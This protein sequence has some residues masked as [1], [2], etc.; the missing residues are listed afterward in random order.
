MGQKVKGIYSSSINDCWKGWYLRD[1]QA[2]YGNSSNEITFEF[3]EVVVSSPVENREDSLEAKL[4]LSWLGLIL[5]GAK[6]VIWKQGFFYSG[7]K[8]LE[9]VLFGR[10][11]HLVDIRRIIWMST[12]QIRCA[13][14]VHI[15]ANAV[16]H[17]RDRLEIRLQLGAERLL[18]GKE[19]PSSYL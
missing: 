14:D 7:C 11:P 19:M 2:R 5:E 18:Q 8:F 3:R 16:A 13:S 6:R 9:K 4:K 17:H 10:L 12:G 1:T 15:I